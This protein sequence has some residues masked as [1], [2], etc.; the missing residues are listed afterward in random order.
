[1]KHQAAPDHTLHAQIE[2]EI[3]RL[4][5]SDSEIAHAMHRKIQAADKHGEISTVN[6]T[7]YHSLKHLPT[8]TCLTIEALTLL[9][10]ANCYTWLAYSLYDDILDTHQP[11]SLPFANEFA[12]TAYALYIQA[13]APTP[14]VAR[15]FR[16]VDAANARES[17]LR[18]AVNNRGSKTTAYLPE[19]ED[20]LSEKSIAHCLG[21]F[22]IASQQ[23]NGDTTMLMGGFQKYCAARQLSDDIYDWRDDYEHKQPTFAVATLMSDA[24]PL[25][26]ETSQCTLETLNKVFWKTGLEQLC[27]HVIALVKESEAHFA[28]LLVHSSPYFQCFIQPLANSAQSAIETHQHTRQKLQQR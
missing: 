22:W 28:P 11:A 25:L 6:R 4:N 16:A 26:G 14:L 10:K 8:S 17:T 12:R 9:D 7:F 5:F 13:G 15:F 1:M 20:L 18:H 2:Q 27:T 24:A 23:Q 19:Y 21:Q 3:S